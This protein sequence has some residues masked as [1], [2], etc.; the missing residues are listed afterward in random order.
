M[1]KVGF[2]QLNNDDLYHHAV[3]IVAGVGANPKFSGLSASL[4]PITAATNALKA[5]IVVPG[6]EGR[7]Q[8]VAGERTALIPLLQRLVDALQIVPGVTNVDLAGT[9]YEL[10]QPNHHTAQPPAMPTGLR[11]KYAGIT[12]ELQVLLNAVPRA[13][14]YEVEYTLDPVNGPWTDVP[15][16]GSTRGMTLTGLTRGKDYWW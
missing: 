10:R 5:A 13:A 11:L 9:G 4:P 14:F 6:G 12:G 15:A 2:T 1:L 7:E 3:A 16:F 8:S